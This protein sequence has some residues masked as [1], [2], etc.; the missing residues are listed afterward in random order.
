M[1]SL[2]VRVL[3]TVWLGLAAVVPCYCN[4]WLHQIYVDSSQTGVNDSS[5]WEGGY[6]TPCLSLNLALKGAQHYN[7]STAILLQPGQHQLHSGS[8][9]QLKNML[10]LAIVGNGSEGEVVIT[11]QP[12]A[13]L[14]FFRSES[15]ELRNVSMIG[16][17]ALQNSTSINSRA[18]SIQFLQVHVAVQ[19]DGCR[20]VSMHFVQVNR[21]TGLGTAIYNSVGMIHIDD[22][23]FLQNGKSLESYGGGGLTI[24]FSNAHSSAHLSIVSTVFEDNMASSGNFSALTPS[25]SRESYFGLGRG[26]GLSIALR[27]GAANNI[28]QLSGVRLERNTAQFGGGLYLALDG[29]TGNNAITIDSCDVMGNEAI[30]SVVDIVSLSGGGGIFVAFPPSKSISSMSNAINIS[31]TQFTSNVASYGGGFGI[32]VHNEL[33]S[34]T[35]LV[36]NCTFRYNSAFQGSSAYFYQDSNRYPSMDT[37]IT[38]ATFS[39]GQCS[40]SIITQF[41]LPCSGNVYLQRYSLLLNDTIILR[42]NGLS[43]LTMSSSHVELLPGTQLHFIN[44][45]ALEGAGLHLVDCSAVIVSDNSAIY[46]DSNNAAIKGGA[47][48]AENCGI[49]QNGGGQCFVRHVNKD[50][51]PDYW[52]V[53]FTFVNNTASD[54]KNSIHVNSIRPCI[55]T[56]RNYFVEQTFCWERWSYM[57]DGQEER[58]LSQLQSDPAFVNTSAIGN[59]TVFPGETINLTNVEVTDDWGRDMDQSSLE[60]EVLSGPVLLQSRQSDPGKKRLTTQAQSITLL[61]ADCSNSTTYY[62]Q[63]SVL[64]IGPSR[65]SGIVN[66]Q[67]KSCNESSFSLNDSICSIQ[68]GCLQTIQDEYSSCS[69]GLECTFDMLSGTS[70]NL[71]PYTSSITIPL[72]ACMSQ[73]NNT[74]HFYTGRCPTTYRYQNPLSLYS[75]DSVPD[76]LLNTTQIR[77]LFLSQNINNMTC[78]PHR[79]GR[80]CGK[81]T[82]GYGV[83]FNSPNFI[84]VPCESYVGAVMFVLLGILPV[85][86]MMTIFA[87]LHINITDGYLNGF[88]L[89]SQLLTLQFPG[90]GYP[91]WVFSSVYINLNAFTT[92]IGITSFYSIWNL[93]FLIVYPPFCIPHVETAAAA[94][95][96]QYVMAFCPLVFIAVTYTWIELYSR[97]YKFVYLVTKV[98]HKILA[99]FWQKFNI[100]PSLIDTYAGL[101][102]LS[103]MRFLAVSVKTL[104]YTFVVDFFVNDSKKEVAFYYDA[105][106]PYFGLPHGLLGT[107]G[108]LCLVLFVFPPI[109][110]FLF[111]HLKIFRK[112][113]SWCKLDRPGFH[114]LVDAY[115]GCF[116]N[117]ASDGVER[118]F[119]AGIYL[120]FRAYIIVIVLG[121][122]FARSY[123]T[124]A[125]LLGILILEGSLSFIMAGLVVLLRP[126]KRTIHNAID[127]FLFFYMSL[128]AALSIIPSSSLFLGHSIAYLPAAVLFFYLIFKLVKFCCVCARS[129]HS[130][131][132]KKTDKTVKQEPLINS[133]GAEAASEVPR[134]VGHSNVSLSSY[135]A[136]DMF[137]DRMLN[138]SQYK[139]EHTHYHQIEDD[140]DNP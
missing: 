101:L 83:A 11:C 63:N 18:D 73:D 68:D 120:L 96:L 98:P 53:N 32:E 74:K 65:L 140:T 27:E 7:H 97:G 124:T 8:E 28:V 62:Q 93:N 40:A 121:N 125:N 44:N 106:M 103:F 122:Y 6:S 56:G 137:A 26:G 102:V 130:K 3:V 15:I 94:I 23:Y 41:A 105:S 5:C 4:Q 109:I 25:N 136:D 126:Y 72:G 71:C 132:L 54:I 138:P 135:I 91:S 52:E 17:G 123:I 108:L 69:N 81:C 131:R 51:H 45:T 22:C 112:C 89:Y 47:I 80:L 127:F 29:N 92:L 55:W 116:K 64:S 113:L 70:C 90:L 37:K 16:C 31:T 39:S 88:I 13:G 107:F 133:L 79:E 78:G 48:L 9:T 119:F 34:N 49:T 36:E 111:Y 30:L 128:I 24:E 115:Q 2:H 76:S 75:D 77:D 33:P 61:A 134:H 10:Q 46:F 19:F 114:A 50:L 35:L 14:A 139:E 110:T 66:V 85:F 57:Y 104:Q 38:K 67:F 84:C 95:G 100:R 21:S 118:R 117:S 60:I 129:R 42:D 12:L 59:I 20:D 58:C 99:R 87:V 86:V 1:S 82:E 43:G